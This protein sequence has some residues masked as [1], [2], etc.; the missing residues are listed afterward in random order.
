MLPHHCGTRSRFNFMSGFTPNNC[1]L[2]TSS[3]SP[4]H[5]PL[6]LSSQMRRIPVP[7]L[8]GAAPSRVHPHSGCAVTRALLG[9][10][11]TTVPDGMYL[12]QR[13]K[14]CAVLYFNTQFVILCNAMK[15]PM[16]R[17]T[18]KKRNAYS[19]ETSRND[20]GTVVRFAPNSALPTAHPLYG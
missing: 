12:I 15:I 18:R 6:F 4:F 20:L 1:P 8:C 5:N 17:R 9:A 2:T 14:R 10:K 3:S 7:T 16:R 19:V 13:Y 11:R